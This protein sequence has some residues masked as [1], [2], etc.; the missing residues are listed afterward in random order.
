[1]FMG[2]G[3]NE[4]EAKIKFPYTLCIMYINLKINILSKLI[5]LNK[6]LET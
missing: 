6:Q 1:M 5:S 4:I 2:T 3:Q